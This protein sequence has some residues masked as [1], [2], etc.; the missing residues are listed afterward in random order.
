LPGIASGDDPSITAISRDVAPSYS[1]IYENGV[2]QQQ[3][4]YKNGRSL[5]A[6]SQR[7]G[8]KVQGSPDYMLWVDEHSGQVLALER[9]VGYAELGKNPSTSAVFTSNAPA[10]EEG[11]VW[12]AL[13]GRA[14]FQPYDLVRSTGLFDPTAFRLVLDN[15]ITDYESTTA[16]LAAVGSTG[17]LAYRWL[18]SRSPIGEVRYQ[19]L[20]LS[21][22]TPVLRSETAVGRS[23]NVP[24]LG[25]VTI[26]QVWARWDPRWQAFALTWS[27]FARPNG[28]AAGQL[29]GSNPFIYTTDF[30]ASWRLADGTATNLPLTYATATPTMMP[31]DDLALGESSNWLPRDLGFSPGGIPWI[32]L[33]AS[34]QPNN[35]HWTIG[36]FRWLAPSWRFFPL[37]SDMQGAADSIGCGATRDYLVCAYSEL[38]DAGALK[39]R[40]SRDDGQTWSAPVT[41]ETIGPTSDGTLQ[42]IS[43]VSYVQPADRYLDNAARFF[44]GFY[45][46]ADVDGM[47]YKN[48]VCWVRVQVGPR[49]DFNGDG[50]A[51]ESDAAD[52]S[53]SHSAGE[54]RADFNDDGTVDDRDAAAFD[55]ALAGTEPPD[56]G[57]PCNPP[58]PGPNPAGTAFQQATDGLVSIEAEHFETPPNGWTVTAQSGTSNSAISKASS[59]PTT[60]L[61][62]RDNRMVYNI[63]FTRAGTHWVW[64][65]MRGFATNQ[66]TLRVGLDE[67]ALLNRATT[68]DSIWRW[69]KVATA[70]NVPSPGLHEFRVYRAHAAVE[71][72][73]VVITPGTYKPTSLGPAESPRN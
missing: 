3:G 5:H 37:S 52:F 7:V 43:W 73:K 65:R 19:E 51:T 38:S 59:G 18:E 50:Q 56:T 42:R 53:A 22:A 68:T 45:R 4:S 49:A 36:F 35:D 25:D 26:E 2:K 69:K 9:P 28:T 47:K 32:T 24:N 67:G 40:V 39:V 46:T 31:R 58:D 21:G 57:V 33:S 12:W 29:F 48:R 44:V 61:S 60:P 55:A 14:N 70:I 62:N 72:D 63:N 64:V 10:G 15:F 1:W 41:V 6:V 17:L 23:S 54:W 16:T 20:D 13:G 30:G 66:K 11:R 27:W 8:T 34:P 71:V